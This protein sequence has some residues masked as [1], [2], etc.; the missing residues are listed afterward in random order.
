MVFSDRQKEFGLAKF[1]T[2]PERCRECKFS[3]ACNGECPKNRLIRTRLE[4]EIGL[5][6]LC[7]G[8]QKFWHHTARSEPLRRQ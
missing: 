7:S 6:Y 4:G 5:N 2:L 8:V 1:G 3:F